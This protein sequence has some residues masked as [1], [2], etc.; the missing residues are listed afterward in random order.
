M[1][2]TPSL[3]NNQ[4]HSFVVFGYPGR[5]SDTEGVISSTE[6]LLPSIVRLGELGKEDCRIMTLDFLY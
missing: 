2:Y 6:F 1:A 3:E 4:V 5:I